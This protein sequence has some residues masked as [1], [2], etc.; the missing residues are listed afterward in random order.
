MIYQYPDAC[1]PFLT[2]AISEPKT[3]FIPFRLF[4]FK[5]KCH[6]QLILAL[7]YE[8]FLSKAGYSKIC[9]NV[10]Q[11]Q[12]LILSTRNCFEQ[13]DCEKGPVY[14]RKVKFDKKEDLVISTK[15]M[16]FVSEAE[17]FITF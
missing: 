12:D 16:K 14:D 6:S 1:K 17:Q 15:K 13:L 4:Q 2:V 8:I 10:G 9:K 7:K 11:G 3:N 5:M